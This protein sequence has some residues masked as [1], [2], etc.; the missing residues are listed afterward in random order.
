MQ[1]SRVTFYVFLILGAAGCNTTESKNEKVHR[2]PPE[3][4]VLGTLRSEYPA[5]R[6]LQEVRRELVEPYGSDAHLYVFEKDQIKVG[7][8]VQPW[9]G[10]GWDSLI[11]YQ[12]NAS[13]EQ[14]SPCAVWNPYAMKVR[15]TFDNSTGMI[16]VRSGGGVLIFS[17]NIAAFKA[18]QNPYDW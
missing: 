13:R 9:G 2:A 15:V 16:E 5:Y 7:V 3:A 1:R 12:F 6:T 10:I 8:C 4:R 11:I 14:W 17:A 18:R